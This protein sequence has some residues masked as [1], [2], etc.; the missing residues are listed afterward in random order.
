MNDFGLR[1]EV[2]S[3]SLFSSPFSSPFVLPAT[4]WYLAIPRP[5]LDGFHDAE[6][7]AGLGS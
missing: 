4:Y 7:R 3:L 2:S 6:S 5:P 1:L